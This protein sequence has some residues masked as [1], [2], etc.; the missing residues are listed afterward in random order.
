MTQNALDEFVTELL[1]QRA[2]ITHR[3]AGLFGTTADRLPLVGPVPGHDGVWVSAGYSG[4]G[5]VL[6]LACGELLGRAVL[7]ERAPELEPFRPGAIARGLSSDLDLDRRE[8]QLVGALHSSERDGEV[9]NRKAGGI[10]ARDLNLRPAA[11]RASREHVGRARS[12][13]R[14]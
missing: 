14:A 8:V 12:R 2:A 10:E 11:G 5:N 4:H 3:W 6:G 9:L 13:H 7:G 1:G